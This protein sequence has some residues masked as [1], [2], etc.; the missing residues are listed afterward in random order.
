MNLSKFKN[1]EFLLISISFGIITTLINYSFGN[2]DQIEQLPIVYRFLDSSYL[3][4][5]FFVNSNDGYSPRYFYTHL[6]GFL[7]KFISLPTLFFL[8]TIFSNISVSLLTFLTAKKLFNSNFSGIISAALVMVIPTVSIGSAYHIYITQFT[9]TALVFPLI[10]LSFYFLINKK[11][12]LSLLITGII[13]IVHVLI[14][15]EYGVLFLSISIIMDYREKRNSK[16]LWRKVFLGIGIMIFLLP[17]LI[18]YYSS[19][20]TIEASSFIEILANFR[21]PHHYLLSTILTNKEISKLLLYG[22][23]F[24]VFFYSWKRRT[25]NEF[26]TIQI[27][28]ITLI[29]VGLSIISWFFT[30]IIPSKLIVS[31]QLLRLLDILKWF[32]IL[33]VANGIS[34]WCIQKKIFPKFRIISILLLFVLVLYKPITYFKNSND[35]KYFELI[36]LEVSKNDISNYIKENTTEKSL[37]LTPHDFGFVRVYSKRAI[38]VDYKAF[39]FQNAAMQEWYKRIKDCYGLEKDK[40][41]EKYHQLTDEKIMTLHKEYGFN[42]AILHNETSTKIPVLYK[43]EKY[44][45]VDLAKNVQ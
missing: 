10:L 15:F 21:H 11:L 8:G 3:V 2:N 36:T 1:T 4:N 13:S 25:K 27:K 39:P 14:G 20:T 22:S 44:K 19:N 23:L 45:I 16:I 38:V 26:Y 33:L 28:T 41:E 6:I 29:L 7:T 37:F 34:N 5:D 35:I 18:P 31:L 9:P 32:T 30:E 42:Y 43:N 12:I 24:I 17:N 40:F